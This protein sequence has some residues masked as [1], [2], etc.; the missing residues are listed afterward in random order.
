VNI[1]DERPDPAY[2]TGGIPNHAAVENFPKIGGQ[3]NTYEITAQGD[4]LVLVLNGLETVNVH[5]STYASGPITLQYGGGTV[6][7]R[8]VEIRPL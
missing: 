6:R 8:K 3:W 4:H 2:G 7:F 5:D 1:Y